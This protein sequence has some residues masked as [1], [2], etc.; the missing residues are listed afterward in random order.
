MRHTYLVTY[1]I[2]S[3]RR[4]QKVFRTMR[5]FG[6][7]IQYSVFLCDLTPRDRV[8][9]ERVMKELIDNKEDQILVIRLGPAKGQASTRIESIGRPYVTSMCTNIV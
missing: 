5:G 1:D 2:S 6:V 8:R 9:L 3:S 4:L 7:H